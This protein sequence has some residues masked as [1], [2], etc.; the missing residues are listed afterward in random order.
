MKKEL[1]PQLEKTLRALAE[2]I[3]DSYIEN[4]KKQRKNEK[5][6]NKNLPYLNCLNLKCKKPIYA[7]EIKYHDNN[8][9]VICPHC[10]AKIL[11]H[12]SKPKEDGPLFTEFIRVL[13]KSEKIN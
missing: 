7:D 8:T 5:M 10:G 1:D 3:Y 12:L 11:V 2:I 9:T 13:D 6:E 4:I